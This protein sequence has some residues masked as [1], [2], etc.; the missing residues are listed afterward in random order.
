MNFIIKVNVFCCKIRSGKFMRNRKIKQFL[1]NK[2]KF[3]EIL[4]PKIVCVSVI[5]FS[6]LQILAKKPS[7]NQIIAIVQFMER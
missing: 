3:F 5:I 7:I 4:R 1:L 6:H 2:S